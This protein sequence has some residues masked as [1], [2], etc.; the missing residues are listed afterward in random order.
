MKKGGQHNKRSCPKETERNL[1]NHS[2]APIG[3][4]FFFS[5][6][7][8]CRIGPGVSW[9]EELWEVRGKKELT[10]HCPWSW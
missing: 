9:L 3:R 7:I 10:H 4:D 2:V 5:I 6:I 8:S 1:T